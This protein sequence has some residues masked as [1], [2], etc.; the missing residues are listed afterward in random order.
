MKEEKKNELR[1]VSREEVDRIL[2]GEMIELSN[3]ACGSAGC[4]GCGSCGGSA[5]CGGSGGCG[6]GSGSGDDDK[7]EK[8]PML[9]VTKNAS[10]ELS[11][12][13]Y[14]FDASASVKCEAYADRYGKNSQWIIHI[15]R[16]DYTFSVSGKN[17]V[18][19]E[20]DKDVTYST[21]GGSKVQPLNNTEYASCSLKCSASSPK[22]KTF[23]AFMTASMSLQVS[24]G[25]TSAQLE[26]RSFGLNVQLTEIK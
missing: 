23:E 13:N 22:N 5:G 10:S 6:C 2:N 14:L 11:S 24:D 20:G 21:S 1:P 8:T 7:Y 16:A 18:V 3:A 12:G 4:G 26:M 9:S 17:N 15:Q 19:R 25:F